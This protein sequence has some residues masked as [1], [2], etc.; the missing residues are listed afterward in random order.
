MKNGF[1]CEE[2]NNK[3]LHL[4]ITID[5][6]QFEHQQT[7]H[8]AEHMIFRRPHYHLAQLQHDF[9]LMQH[10]P[11]P[12]KITLVLASSDDE[13]E[14]KLYVDELVLCARSPVFRGMFSSATSFRDTTTRSINM[15][16]FRPEVVRQFVSYL[17]DARLPRWFLYRTHVAEAF[18]LARDLYEMAKLYQV[19]SLAN[20]CRETLVQ[21]LSVD[22]VNDLYG[23]YEKYN[24]H[25]LKY[26]VK[27]FYSEHLDA[28]LQHQQ[29]QEHQHRASKRIKL[30]SEHLGQQ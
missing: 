14:K 24:D 9:S 6:L 2:E 13:G 30:S 25:L 19:T 20:A 16:H 7:I 21:Q 1:L 4:R 29:H 26:H 12:A 5:L 28:I 23:L 11:H 18:P 17:Y 3:A 10:H 8:G 15:Q 22:V 27:L